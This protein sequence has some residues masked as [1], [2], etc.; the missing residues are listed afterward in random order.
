MRNMNILQMA[1]ELCQ[2]FDCCRWM[3]TGIPNF[4]ETLDPL[5]DILKQAYQKAGNVDGVHW[6]A[7]RWTNCLGEQYRNEQS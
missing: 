6:N 5:N 1:D 7:S 2:F 3:S 4:Y